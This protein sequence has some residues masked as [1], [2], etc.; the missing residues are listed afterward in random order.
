MNCR[1]RLVRHAAALALV[2]WYLVVAPPGQPTKKSLT[3]LS[4][5]NVRFQSGYRYTDS[6]RTR[7]RND[8]KINRSRSVTDI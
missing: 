1:F 6:T 8:R 3:A 2:G 7:V 5:E 4:L